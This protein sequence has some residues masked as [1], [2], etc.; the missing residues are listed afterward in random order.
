MTVPCRF[1]GY[2]E[3]ELIPDFMNCIDVLVLPSR[4]EGLPLVSLEAIKCGAGVVA[5]SGVGASEYI[6]SNNVFDITA[7][8]FAE[9]I[10]RRAV[11][12]LNGDVPAQT[13]NKD[14]TWAETAQL[15]NAIYASHLSR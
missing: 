7:P 6:G 3:P 15:E 9:H 11:A 4:R 14:M 13:L 5:S 1:W 12:M 8:D 10:S 2:Q